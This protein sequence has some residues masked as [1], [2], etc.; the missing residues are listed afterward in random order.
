MSS[1]AGPTSCPQFGQTPSGSSFLVIEGG[2]V[3]CTAPGGRCREARIRARRACAGRFR[4]DRT[5]RYRP[6]TARGI[7]R[8]ALGPPLDTG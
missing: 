4:T 2:S 8:R 5:W 3:W 1:E 7:P 6:P